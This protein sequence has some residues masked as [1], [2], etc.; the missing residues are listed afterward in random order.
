M[1]LKELYSR[2]A[3]ANPIDRT[4]STVMSPGTHYEPTVDRTFS[5]MPPILPFNVG[6][7]ANPEFEDLT[8]RKLG[9]MQVMGYGGKPVNRAKGSLWVCRC[10]CGRFEM[11]STRAIKAQRAGQS[12][13]CCEICNN[14]MRIRDFGKTSYFSASREDRQ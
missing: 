6:L 14:T 1:S 13:N 9:Y 4:A 11:R 2:V 7:K 8:G 3:T 12:P 5:E 10:V